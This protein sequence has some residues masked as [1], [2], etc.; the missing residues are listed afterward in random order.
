MYVDVFVNRLI[1][2]PNDFG[3]KNT[4]CLGIIGTSKQNLSCSVN[5][6]LH[7]IRVKDA[8][9]TL[10]VK[11][12]MVKFIFW[13]L[14]NP[15]VNKILDSWT[16]NTYTHDGYGIDKLLGGM[17]INFFCEYPCATCD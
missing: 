12:D 11:P 6:D 4:S 3:S 17:K 10:E 5:R 14:T 2:I 8:F 13:G 9:D 7:M 15:T 1:G 16:I